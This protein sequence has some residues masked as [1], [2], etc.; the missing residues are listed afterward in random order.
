MHDE[1]RELAESAI[2]TSALLEALANY[3][4]TPQEVA[5][6]L[7]L[8]A[9]SLERRGNDVLDAMDDES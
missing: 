3:D 9:S 6:A 1:M 7:R 2:G 8:V 4:G 5:Y